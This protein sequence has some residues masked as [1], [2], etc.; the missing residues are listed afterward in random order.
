MS[1]IIHKM[2]KPRNCVECMDNELAVALARSGSACPFTRE[3]I[4]ANDFDAYKGVIDGCPIEVYEE[5]SCQNCRFWDNED[6]IVPG[7]GL[8]LKA[9]KMITMGT[10]RCKVGKFEK[11]TDE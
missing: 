6:F 7:H 5:I 10:E 9:G 2:N 8:C 11:R 3:I 4:Y 1:V